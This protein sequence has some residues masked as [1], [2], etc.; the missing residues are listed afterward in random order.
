MK[1]LILALAIALL[2]AQAY[3]KKRPLTYKTDPIAIAARALYDLA[4]TDTGRPKKGNIFV[5]Y[6]P[7]IK[8]DKK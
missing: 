1:N 4:R 8:N 5:Q 3:P 6:G 7:F 2:P